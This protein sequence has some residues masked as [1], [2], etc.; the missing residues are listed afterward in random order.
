MTFNMIEEFQSDQLP[1]NDMSDQLYV[2]FLLFL[3]ILP[4][5]AQDLLIQEGGGPFDVQR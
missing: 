5:V 2:F 1:Q 4:V 3:S